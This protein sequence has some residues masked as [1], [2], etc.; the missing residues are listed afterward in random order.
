MNHVATS[1]VSVA[2]LSN[3]A[4][5]DQHPLIL[6]RDEV[7]VAGIDRSN[8]TKIIRKDPG[9]VSVALEAKMFDQ[10]E[11]LLHLLDILRVLGKHVFVGRAARRSVNKHQ[12][13]LVNHA[14]QRAQVLHSSPTGLGT[15]ATTLNLRPRPEDRLFGSDVEAFGVEECAAVVI[16]QDAEF[17]L[18]DLVEALTWRR[19]ITDHVAEANDAVNFLTANIL[20][21]GFERGQI[22]VD[23]AKDRGA[24]HRRRRYGAMDDVGS[25]AA[26]LQA[27][28]Q[29]VG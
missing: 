21:N 5:V 29:C 9:N 27:I 4:D 23:V 8:E 13:A 1:R 6:V 2:R 18:H 17:K 10:R 19:A 15:V 16:S 20:Q 12:V 24:C 11:Q 26:M 22:A 14:W 3:A 25:L 7:A 28:A